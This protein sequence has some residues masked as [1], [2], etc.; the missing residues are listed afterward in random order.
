M[1]AGEIQFVYSAKEMPKL[2]TQPYLVCGFPGSG[3]SANLPLI[4]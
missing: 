3:T 4:I 2:A 1:P